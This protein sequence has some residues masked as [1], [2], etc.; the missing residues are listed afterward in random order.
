MQRISLA[1]LERRCQKPDHRR[2]GNWLARRI[3]RPAA[4]RITRVVAPWGV[5]ANAATLAAWGCGLAAAVAFGW[6]TAWGWLLGA[7]LLQVW[8][9]LDHVDGQLARLHGTASLDGTQLD[10]LMHHTVNLTVPLG[11]GFG[12]FARTAE[13]LWMLG[14][15]VWGLALL[16]ITLQHD[17]RSKAFF[18]RLKRVRGKLEVVGGGGG[19]PLPQ[20]PIPRSP[21]RLAAWTA[22]KSCETHVVM[23]VLLAVA[24]A[25]Q[26]I[27][28]VGLIAGRFYLAITAPLAAAT[29]AWTVARS[30]ATVASLYLDKAGGLYSLRKTKVLMKMITPGI[31]GGRRLG[32][33]KS[34]LDRRRGISL[35][36]AA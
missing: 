28:D 19:R 8:Y 34:R 7:G 13:P 24:V 27:G 26:A 17:A 3:S 1:E 36:C 5:S 32:D 12:L 15:L 16:V 10:Y 33:R 21:L 35:R 14:G 4:L 31:L 6:G 9:L 11:V 25:Q 29:A 30:L 20:P 22:R 23:T 18:R 2:L